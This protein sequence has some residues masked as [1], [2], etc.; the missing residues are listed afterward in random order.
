MSTR[1]IDRRKGEEERL[2][3]MRIN[4]TR[5]HSL[6]YL[7]FVGIHFD[8]SVC[9]STCIFL[10]CLS[11]FQKFIIGIN[12]YNPSIDPFLSFC[13]WRCRI[14]SLRFSFLFFVYVCNISSSFSFSLPNNKTTNQRWHRFL[15]DFY[16]WLEQF[17]YKRRIL[18]RRGAQLGERVSI[19]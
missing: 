6:L 19:A 2:R 8:S 13:M 3:E 18:Q 12:S 17:D 16:F 7:W 14:D 15:C 10:E 4:W 9:L 5:G 11:I 1:C